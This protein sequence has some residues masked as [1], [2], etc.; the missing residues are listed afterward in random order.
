MGLI[1]LIGNKYGKLTVLERVIIK[2]DKH[3]YWRCKCDCGGEKIARSDALQNGDTSHCGCVNNNGTHHKTG[4]RINNIWGGMKERCLNENCKNYSEYGGRGI[5]ICSE[6]LNDFMSFYNWSME[7]GYSDNLSI[8]RINVNGNYEPGNC[9]W[10]TPKEQSNNT[11]IN[12]LIEIEG[13]IKS[14][15]QWAELSGVSRQTIQRR[16]NKGIKGEEILQPVVKVKAEFQSGIPYIKWDK[17]KRRWR[18]ELKYNG[19]LYF[20]GHIKD[21]EIAKQK[22][23]EL[24]DE[25]IKH[26][27]GEEV[28]VE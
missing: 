17:K 6:W 14:L 18:T 22:Q 2:G 7:N 16:I 10:A 26:S 15:S 9:R 12:N 20:I 3:T 19:K 8:D 11:R 23:L 24:K 4:H 25:L 28:I 21:L 1:S 5:T 27:K 13:E